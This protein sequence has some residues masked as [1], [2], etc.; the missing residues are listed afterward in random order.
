MEALLI[1][2]VIVASLILGIILVEA[3]VVN[4]IDY[5]KYHLWD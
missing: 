1:I 3:L 2:Y 5:I 4:I